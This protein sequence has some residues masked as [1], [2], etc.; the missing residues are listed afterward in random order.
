MHLNR[1]HAHFRVEKVCANV[2][3]V[4]VVI[5]EQPCHLS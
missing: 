2:L 3:N 5:V 1:V 4:Q